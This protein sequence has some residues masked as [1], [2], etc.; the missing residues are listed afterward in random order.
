MEE[1]EIFDGDVLAILRSAASVIKGEVEKAKR[2]DEIRCKVVRQIRGTR[3]AGIA[4]VILPTDQ[5]LVLT[6]EWEDLS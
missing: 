4:V 3:D 6:V 5:L 1:R 2:D